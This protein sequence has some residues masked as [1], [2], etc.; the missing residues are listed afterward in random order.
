MASGNFLVGEGLSLPGFNHYV[1]PLL[2][3]RK[4]SLIDIISFGKY[5]NEN[6]LVSLAGVDLEKSI[7][8]SLVEAGKEL[9]RLMKEHPETYQPHNNTKYRSYEHQ[10]REYKVIGLYNDDKTAAMLFPGIAQKYLAD[11]AS[12]ALEEL[13]KQARGLLD[14]K[15]RNL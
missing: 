12:K 2:E 3:S 6:I 15:L 10:L 11:V 5:S 13:K 14:T 9:E 1:L 4:V 7:D 8:E